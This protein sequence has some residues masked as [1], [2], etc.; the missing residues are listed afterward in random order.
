ML[1]L[2]FTTITITLRLYIIEIFVNFGITCSINKAKIM[3]ML[4]YLCQ[5]FEITQGSIDYYVGLHVH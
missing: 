1:I 3:D 5:H 4:N 2:V